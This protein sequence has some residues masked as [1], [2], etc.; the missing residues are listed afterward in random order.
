[1]CGPLGCSLCSL[2]LNTA[3]VRSEELRTPPHKWESNSGKICW[4]KFN[5]L[6]LLSLSWSLT[7]NHLFWKNIT[8][9][10]TELTYKFLVLHYFS[11]ICKTFRFLQALILHLKFCNPFLWFNKPMNSFKNSRTKNQDDWPPWSSNKL[12]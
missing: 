12:E 4:F 9:P 10:P 8:T 5:G 6:I 11:K 2:C 3:L 7:D 1:M